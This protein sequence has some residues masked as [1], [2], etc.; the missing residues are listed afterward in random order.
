VRKRFGRTEVLRGVSFEMPRGEVLCVI[1]PS[2]SGKST[3]LRSINYLEP[4]TGGLVYLDGEL[5]GHQVRNGRL[6]E[7]SHADLAAKRCQVGMVFQSF[8]L[9]AH[10]TALENVMCGPLYSRRLRRPEAEELA[11][12]LLVSVG[13]EHRLHAY[14]ANL[15]GG[16]QQRVGIARALALEPKVMLFDEPTSALDPE[17][18]GEVLEVVRHLA[19]TGMTMVVVTHELGFAADVADRVMFMDEGSVVEIGPCRSVL[20]DP[21]HP[22]TKAFLGSILTK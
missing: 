16:E 3:L 1:G 14:P 19:G 17:R 7:R 8:N 21:S 13:L 15:S 2:G 18:V 4:P 11:L 12:R 9:F 22:R 5:V 20:D 10:K 6:Y